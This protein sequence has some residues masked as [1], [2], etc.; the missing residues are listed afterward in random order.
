LGQAGHGFDV[1]IDGEGGLAVQ[2]EFADHFLTQGSHVGS[3]LGKQVEM[4]ITTQTS[5][6]ASR[7]CRRPLRMKKS[8]AIPTEP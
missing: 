1:G 8:P 7:C 4:E 3:S 6:F 2:F 5:I